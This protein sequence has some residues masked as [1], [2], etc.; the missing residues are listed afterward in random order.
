MDDAVVAP[1]VKVPAR[2]AARGADPRRFEPAWACT[3]PAFGNTLPTV[4]MFRSAAEHYDSFMGRYTVPLAAAL[5]DAARIA[6][7][8]RVV[9]VG[10]GPGGLTRELADRVGADR[11]AAIDP[12]PQFV[13]ACRERV[14]GADVREGVAEQLPWEDG[15]FDAALSCLVIAFMRDADAGVREMARVTRPGGTVAICMWDLE[16]GGMTMLRLFWTAM[17]SVQPPATGERG[18]PGTAEGDI[19]DRLARAGLTDVE[20]GAL[21]VHVDYT[22]FDDFWNPFTHGVGPAGEALAKLGPRQRE[23]VREACRSE[24]PAGGSPFRLSARAWFGRGT[25]AG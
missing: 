14:A 1:G 15:S 2:A 5:A 8:I 16:Q 11:V 19:A 9:D 17:R 13:A 20:S 6:T 21:E 25:V 23:A 7:A 3:E 12:A 18:R 24:L 10:C 4:A 22:D